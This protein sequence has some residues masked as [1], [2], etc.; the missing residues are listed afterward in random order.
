M[1]VK[2]IALNEN[3]V[4]EATDRVILFGSGPQIAG[5]DIL[6]RGGFRTKCDRIFREVV[7]SGIKLIMRQ[8]ETLSA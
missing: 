6:Y 4:M 3:D 8:P 7:K 2:K 1:F 5:G